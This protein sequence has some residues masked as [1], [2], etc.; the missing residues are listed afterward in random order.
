MPKGTGSPVKS[1]DRIFD[2]FE[3]LALRTDGLTQQAI[4]GALE[5]PKSSV[6]ATEN[7]DCERPEFH[8]YAGRMDFEAIMRL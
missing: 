6:A 5:I 4:A 7:C 2:L 1:A 8:A 3:L